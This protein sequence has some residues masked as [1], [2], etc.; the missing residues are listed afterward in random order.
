MEPAHNTECEQALLGAILLNNDAF[1]RCSDFLEAEHFF[2]PVHQK[3][4]EVISTLIRSGKIASPVTLKGFLPS[5]TKIAGLTSSQYLARLCAEATTVIIAPDYARAVRDYSDR[6]ALVRLSEEI[7]QRV[8]APPTEQATSDIL[9]D[10]EEKLIGLTSI[11]AGRGGFM[12]FSD[13]LLGTMEMASAAYQRDGHL[14]GLATGLTDLDRLMGGIQKSDLVILA[15]RPSM[16]KTALAT[17][18]A[19][20]VASEYRGRPLSDGSV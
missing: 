9:L 6:R 12:R 14:S 8:S 19:Y 17:N 11:D 15:G 1:Y 10:A 5:D 13:A 4:Y 20:H 2:E 16:G 7:A 3:I 18:I